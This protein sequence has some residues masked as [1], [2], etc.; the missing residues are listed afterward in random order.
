MQ[1]KKNV[2]RKLLQEEEDEDHIKQ[3]MICVKNNN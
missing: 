1:L 3:E 2:V